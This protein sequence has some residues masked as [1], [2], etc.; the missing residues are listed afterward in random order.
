MCCSAASPRETVAFVSFLNC[1]QL[2]LTVTS[3]L[4]LFRATVNLPFRSLH[5]VTIIEFNSNM[6]SFY[7][8]FVLEGW[9]VWFFCFVFSFWLQL[10][11]NDVELSQATKIGKGSYLF[12]E[13][14]DWRNRKDTNASGPEVNRKC[15]VHLGFARSLSFSS[16]FSSPW[17]C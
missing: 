2:I 1:S 8:C 13:T 5:Q 12:I 16:P 9:E 11:E 7:F 15:P 4:R 6:H 3:T 17:L 14:K 10:T